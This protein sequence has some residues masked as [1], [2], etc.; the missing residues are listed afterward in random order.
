MKK[1]RRRRR[2]CRSKKWRSSLWFCLLLVLVVAAVGIWRILP[3]ITTCATETAGRISGKGEIQNAGAELTLKEEEVETD[4]YYQQLNEKEKTAYKEL[5]QGVR[6]MQENITL[7]V[8]KEEDA[9]KIYEALLYDRPELFWCNG[10]SH[11]VVYPEYTEFSPSYSCSAEQKEERQERIL[12]A[13]LECREQ[14]PETDSEYEKIKSVFEYIVNTVEYDENAADNQNIYS[15]LVNHRSVCAGYSRS[16]QY[17]LKRFGIE[18]IYVTGDVILPDGEKGAHAW[19]IVKCDETYYQMDVTF[20][21]PLFLENEN[22]ED[23]PERMINYEYLC[24]TDEQIQRDHI[25]DERADYPVCD[26]D[27]LNYYKMNGLYY[28]EFDS[29]EILRKMKEGIAEKEEMFVCSFKNEKIYNQAKQQMIENLLPMAAQALAEQ[30]SLEQV[31]YT[32][33]EDKVQYIFSVFWNY[34]DK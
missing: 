30:Y 2:D 29:D 26:S 22:R 28:D 21:D 27:D 7:H 18:C 10:D 23:L 20:G 14:L 24:C 1:K 17:L 4:F 13:E 5:L 32:Y 6:K 19:N 15:A 31:K 11:M 9:G 3:E 8:G 33:A 25:P 12:Q 16:A 34:D